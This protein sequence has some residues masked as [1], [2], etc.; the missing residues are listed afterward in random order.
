MAIPIENACMLSLQHNNT[1]TFK[2]NCII[3]HNG[4][5]NEEGIYLNNNRVSH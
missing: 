5:Q 2:L 1:Q 4:M 3:Q